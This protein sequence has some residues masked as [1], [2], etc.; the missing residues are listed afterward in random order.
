MSWGIEFT[1]YLSRVSKD[2]IDAEIEETEAL[3]RQEEHTLHALAACSPFDAKDSEG[4]SWDWF[5][6]VAM[7]VNQATESLGELHSKLGLL[8]QAKD[9]DD[10]KGV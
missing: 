9:S 1:A 3:I 6:Y 7:K 5:E 8:Y 2:R 10:V 4:N